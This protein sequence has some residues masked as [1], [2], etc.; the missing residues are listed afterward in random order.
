MYLCLLFSENLS[1]MKGLPLT[2]TIPHLKETPLSSKYT[3]NDFKCL[4]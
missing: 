4:L 2:F 3:A 1:E